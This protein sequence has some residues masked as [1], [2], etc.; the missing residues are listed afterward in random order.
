MDGYRRLERTRSV[1]SASMG[2]VA[3]GTVEPSEAVRERRSSRLSRARIA[4]AARLLAFVGVLALIIGTS[5]SLASADERS[6]PD[7]EPASASANVDLTGSTSEADPVEPATSE[8]P[9]PARDARG[10]DKQP[11]P[12]AIVEELDPI[13]PTAVDSTTDVASANGVAPTGSSL[14][15][16]GDIQV[17]WLLLGGAGLVLLGMLVQIGGQPL[18]VRARART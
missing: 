2:A 15:L 16:T 3:V 8:N 11:E 7:V 13:E 6:A 14:P 5:V 1:G 18:P 9:A 12:V 4:G 17:R 10:A